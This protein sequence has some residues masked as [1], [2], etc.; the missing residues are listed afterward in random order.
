MHRFSSSRCASFRLPGVV[1]VVVFLAVAWLAAC[2]TEETGPDGELSFLLERER[3]RATAV[4]AGV[5]EV[6]G[7]DGSLEHTVQIV[8]RRDPEGEQLT[9]F[10]VAAGEVEGEHPVSVFGALQGFASKPSGLTPVT[11]VC[12][13]GAQAEAGGSLTIEEVDRETR[14]VSGSFLANVCDVEQPADAKTLADGRFDDVPYREA[15]PDE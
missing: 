6:L 8:A 9:L 14:T 12:G 4:S 13:T 3:W 15:G 5:E 7:E 11:N 2:A 1:H 10:A